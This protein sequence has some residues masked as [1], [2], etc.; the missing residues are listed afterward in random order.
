MK[1][2]SQIITILL[3]LAQ[4]KSD[5]SVYANKFHIEQAVADDGVLLA[6]IITQFLNENFNEKNYFV[7]IVLGQSRKEERH[8]QVDFFTELFD[9]PIL[10]KF[11]FNVLNELEEPKIR[12]KN[13]FHLMLVDNRESLK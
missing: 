6:D 12:K 5:E 13:T 11:S 2:P 8:F 10:T 3:L 9:D 4:Y 7:S 1:I